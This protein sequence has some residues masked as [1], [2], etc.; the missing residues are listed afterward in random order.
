MTRTMHAGTAVTAACA[1]A[2]APAARANAGFALNDGLTDWTANGYAGE[3]AKAYDAGTAWTNP[4]GM[5]RL[6]GNELDASV[7]FIDPG[8]T[9]VGSDEIGG[10][11]VA[12][13]P[14]AHG[15]DPAISAGEALVVSL[16]RDLKFGFSV[17]SPFASRLSA[18]PAN[19]VG[20]YQDTDS[21][22]TVVQGLFSLAYAVD[23]HLSIGGGPYISY[24]RDRQS[25]AVD[26][27]YATV[28][29]VPFPLGPP[30]ADPTAEY[31]GD[32]LAAG[33][34]LSVLYQFND[35]LRVGVN[36]HSRVDHTLQGYQTIAIAPQVLATPLGP[37][38]GGQLRSQIDD[39]NVKQT[40][41][42]WVDTSI[43]WQVTPAL[44]L[45]ANATWTEWSLFQNSRINPD[46]PALPVTTNIQYNFHDTVTA[47]I[48]ANYRLPSLQR[49]LMQGGVT[50]DQ[51]P[52][53]D[54]TRQA[55]LPD[56]DR[57]ELGLGATYR[58]TRALAL[59]IA[60]THYFFIDANNI[61]NSIGDTI[62]KTAL[63]TIDLPAG[64]LTGH[65]NINN[66]AL[67][68]GLKAFF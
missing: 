43:Y 66:N 32:D 39:A 11:T 45:L 47:G 31:R 65:Y 56:G 2:L 1:I 42:G 12:G 53:D 44:A 40:L 61:N 24:F 67:S 58:V 29:G 35:R 50:F 27:T 21:I 16:T 6:Q 52:V 51:S 8:L 18:A 23:R 26:L 9:F 54:S 25:H 63:G 22:P 60:Y 64:T 30:G 59:S 62:N 17:Q 10:Q 49:L 7:N 37:L 55:S 33:Y 3:A 36:Y 13:P 4:A 41:P 20:R 34:D 28:S 19:Y 57:I 15:I 48:G 38:V 68:V 14:E 5:V 46:N